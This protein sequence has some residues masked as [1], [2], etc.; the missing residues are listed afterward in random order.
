MMSSPDIDNS[1]EK[2]EVPNL[3]PPKNEEFIPY[4]GGLASAPIRR[5]FKA[6]HVLLMLIMFICQLV[7]MLM[8]PSTSIIDTQVELGYHM[9]L[10]LDM[11][12]CVT[13]FVEHKNPLSKTAIV[14][15]RGWKQNVENF[16]RM[17]NEDK[18]F[19]INPFVWNLDADNNVTGLQ[20]KWY[21]ARASRNW[22]CAV[23]VYVPSGG[24][25][26]ENSCVDTR[27]VN[28]THGDGWKFR[29]L[30]V[31]YQPIV[32][33]QIIRSDVELVADS[34]DIQLSMAD[35]Y[36][37]SVISP[38]FHLVILNGTVD[39]NLG[40]TSENFN[41]K[42]PKAW[43][44]FSRY[45]EVKVSSSVPIDVTL[46]RAEAAL[47]F[48]RGDHV[49]QISH[50]DDGL[51]IMAYSNASKARGWFN[52]TH[53]ISLS[54]FSDEAPLYINV[55]DCLSDELERQN[56]W[57]GSAHLE[58]PHFID[59]SA[60]RLKTHVLSVSA[61]AAHSEPWRAE[62]FTH[63][64]SLIPQGNWH[65]YSS[66]A[67]LRIQDYFAFLSGG[68]LAPES[69]SF[70][71]TFLGAFCRLK[72]IKR[73]EVGSG[74]IAFEMKLSEDGSSNS[75]N[76]TSSN[77]HRIEAGRR[78]LEDQTLYH[79]D[80]API[81]HIGID[82]SKRLG[83][84]L[85]DTSW[86]L[87]VETHV[88]HMMTS[89]MDGV[90]D[91]TEDVVGFRPS[92][93]F[94]GRVHKRL[95]SSPREE[96]NAALHGRRL[97]AYQK[98]EQE[99][100]SPSLFSDRNRREVYEEVVPN[101]Y[102]N[103]YPGVLIPDLSPNS[104]C[105]VEI[106]QYQFQGQMDVVFNLEMISDEAFKEQ[107]RHIVQGLRSGASRLTIV[108][109]GVCM[110]Y[111]IFCDS[112]R[113]YNALP[114]DNVVYPT[115]YITRAIQWIG[116]QLHHLSNNNVIHKL[117][118]GVDV[119]RH[120]NGASTDPEQIAA[121][122]VDNRRL[123]S[124]EVSDDPFLS[125]P[126]ALAKKRIFWRKKK[127]R[128]EKSEWMFRMDFMDKEIFFMEISGVLLLAN[129]L[130][131]I[132]SS[133]ISVVCAGRWSR[134]VL[135][136]YSKHIAIPLTNEQDARRTSSQR[137][138]SSKNTPSNRNSRSLNTN[139]VNV[140]FPGF[141]LTWVFPLPADVDNL[142]VEVSMINP[143][144]GRSVLHSRMK[145]AT[146]F[147]RYQNLVTQRGKLV[148][149]LVVLASPFQFSKVWLGFLTNIGFGLSQW[150]LDQRTGVNS[151]NVQ[152]DHRI[153]N[154][155][156]ASFDIKI[157]RAA[158]QREDT[159]SG[160]QHSVMIPLVH[161][162]GCSR[163][164]F[165]DGPVNWLNPMFSFAA[166]KWRLYQLR[167]YQFR[168]KACDKDGHV[169]ISSNW[170]NSTSFNSL[171]PTENLMLNVVQAHLLGTRQSPRT[172]HQFM[173]K[174]VFR[175]R[176]PFVAYIFTDIKLFIAPTVDNFAKRAFLVAMEN[177]SRNFPDAAKIRNNT[178]GGSD[179]LDEG[180]HR[181]LYSDRT[182][183]ED[184]MLSVRVVMGWYS[185][186]NKRCSLLEDDSDTTYRITAVPKIVSPD[187]SMDTRAHDKYVLLCLPKE[188]FKQLD[189]YPFAI[190]ER[191]STLHAGIEVDLFDANTQQRLSHGRVSLATILEKAI[192][193]YID[194][195]TALW[196][197]VN[198]TLGD[199]TS[200]FGHLTM[201]V[202]IDALKPFL[203][204]L[205]DPRRPP[206]S[207]RINVVQKVPSA[208]RKQATDIIFPNFELSSRATS[209]E[210]AP[211]P[212]PFECEG[213]DNDWFNM[214]MA[215]KKQMKFRIPQIS[216]HEII[217][218]ASSNF[219]EPNMDP[220]Q[221]SRNAPQYS[222]DHSLVPRPGD[223]YYE[224]MEL[225]IR[226]NPNDIRDPKGIFT[227]V[228]L[229]LHELESGEMLSVL[230][231]AR[232]A[233][234]TG[235][236]TWRIS[237]PK[238]R[239]KR[240]VTRTVR[241]LHGE[242]MSQNILHSFIRISGVSPFE[243]IESKLIVPRTVVHTVGF[244]IAKPL[245]FRTLE[246]AYA[247]WCRIMNVQMSHLEEA[248][249]EKIGVSVVRRS[250]L[251][252]KDF[253]RPLPFETF[254][255]RYDLIMTPGQMVPYNN[256][257]Q[258]KIT[259]KTRKFVEEEGETAVEATQG[260]DMQ[261]KSQK[262]QRET[263]Q[264]NRVIR[265][266]GAEI[267]RILEVSIVD[268]CHLDTFSD[269][270]WKNSADC[271]ARF[272]TF[273][274]GARYPESG[275]LKTIQ[276][277]R[278]ARRALLGP[279][280]I[281]PPPHD[282]GHEFDLYED[283]VLYFDDLM[284]F[285]SSDVF[286]G[287]NK[288]KT[289]SATEI[290]WKQMAAIN[291]R[292]L[293]SSK[294]S[295]DSDHK[296]ESSKLL[297]A[298]VNDVWKGGHL[299][300]DPIFSLTWIK[301]KFMFRLTGRV[302]WD[303][304]IKYRSPFWSRLVNFVLSYSS[305]KKKKRSFTGMDKPK[306]SDLESR[307]LYPAYP[308]YIKDS[309]GRCQ[310]FTHQVMELF[311][312]PP[313]RV[314]RLFMAY[315]FWGT[316]LTCIWM[317][318]DYFFSILFPLQCFLVALASNF[319]SN[320]FS[321][322]F[323]IEPDPAYPLD[324]V[325]HFSLSFASNWP[326]MVRLTCA[327]AATEI[328]YWL[329]VIAF[330]GYIANMNVRLSSLVKSVSMGLIYMRNSV[331]FFM[332]ALSLCWILV[333]ILVRST[334]VMIMVAGIALL[335]I[336]VNKV[337]V[338]HS[339]KVEQ[340]NA[341]VRNHF[342]ALLSIS[343]DNWFH[344]H[345]IE[346]PSHT[347][348][349]DAGGGINTVLSSSSLK[350]SFDNLKEKVQ[351]ERMTHQIE[352]YVRAK[353]ISEDE[354]ISPYDIC[355]FQ[356]RKITPSQLNS[357]GI[358]E[359]GMPS[360][361]ENELKLPLGSRLAKIA[362]VHKSGEKIHRLLFGFDAVMLLDGVLYG[363][364]YGYHLQTDLKPGM[365]F[366]MALI[367]IPVL[368]PSSKVS[369][370]TRVSMVFDIFNKDNDNYLN[371]V[372]FMI[373][374][375]VL[376]KR[377][378][379]L[380]YE[381][382]LNFYNSEYDC[383]MTLQQGM[384]FT[385][386]RNYYSHHPNELMID[387]EK[388]VFVGDPSKDHVKMNTSDNSQLLESVNLVSV[389]TQVKRTE[390]FNT[391]SI[392][393][394]KLATIFHTL[395]MRGAMSSKLGCGVFDRNSESSLARA[396]VRAENA[397]VLSLIGM[398]N[399]MSVQEFKD[400]HNH[401]RSFDNRFGKY[402]KSSGDSNWYSVVFEAH[403]NLRFFL[404]NELSVYLKRVF[405]ADNI[406]KKVDLFFDQELQRHVQ[407]RVTRIL[408]LQIPVT[409]RD[410]HPM[411]ALMVRHPRY[412]TTGSLL[413]ENFRLWLQ[414]QGGV[415]L[416]L[417]DEAL[418]VVYKHFDAF[419]SVSGEFRDAIHS[420]VYTIRFRIIIH[421]L[422]T[423]LVDAGVLDP[424]R[425]LVRPWRPIGTKDLIIDLIEPITVQCY[426]KLIWCLRGGILKTCG[427]KASNE[428][429]VYG[430]GEASLKNSDPFLRDDRIMTMLTHELN[431]MGPKVRDFTLREGFMTLLESSISILASTHLW[432]NSFSLLLRLGGISL[433]THALPDVYYWNQQEKENGMGTVFCSSTFNP[434]HPQRCYMS[435][436]ADSIKTLGTLPHEL[437]T[438]VDIAKHRSDWAYYK[439]MLPKLYGDCT[440]L[441][442]DLLTPLNNAPMNFIPDD[443]LAAPA[444]WVDDESEESIPGVPKMHATSH[445]MANRNK[446]FK[447]GSQDS[448]TD[449]EPYPSTGHMS[450]RGRQDKKPSDDA[451]RGHHVDCSTKGYNL[452]V[453]QRVLDDLT[454]YGEFLPKNLADEA[455]LR[456]TRHML[457]FAEVIAC[458]SFLDIPV[459]D[460]YVNGDLREI[461]Q[462][463][464]ISNTNQTV[465]LNLAT[466]DNDDDGSNAVQ[467][468]ARLENSL[469]WW[470][471]HCDPGWAVDIEGDFIRL[472]STSPGFMERAQMYILVRL[473][474]ERIRP[475][476]VRKG[477]GITVA[478]IG[479]LL[480]GDSWFQQQCSLTVLTDAKITFEMFNYFCL[481]QRC[482]VSHDHS[483][484]L[485]LLI[486]QLHSRS[487][488]N[489]DKPNV[490]SF[491]YPAA[492]P[493]LAVIKYLVVALSQPVTNNG[494]LYDG[495]FAREIF[496]FRGV[497][498]QIGLEQILKILR[499]DLKAH[500]LRHLWKNLS[501]DPW[502]LESLLA[503]KVVDPRGGRFLRLGM[504][505]F[506]VNPTKGFYIS[507]NTLRD[508][509]RLMTTTGLPRITLDNLI[510]SELNLEVSLSRI[511][512][513]VKTIEHRKNVYGFICYDDV[514]NV[515]IALDSRGLD[516]KM[517]REL[518]NDMKLQISDESILQMFNR[519]D[520]NADY[521][522]SL[523]E[524]LLGFEALY[525]L[526]LPNKILMEM[527][528]SSIH[529]LKRLMFI[530]ASITCSIVFLILS[531]SSFE[532]M[533]G[534]AD[535][536]VQAILMV[537]GAGSIRSS[538]DKKIAKYQWQTEEALELMFDETL[539]KQIE[540]FEDKM[541]QNAASSI[542]KHVS[543]G[544]MTP[545]AVSYIEGVTS[546][547]LPSPN[548]SF[549]CLILRP[550]DEIYWT[551]SITWESASGEMAETSPKMEW[552]S[553]P[554]LDPQLGIALDPQT[555]II[556]GVVA[557]SYQVKHVELMESEGLSVDQTILPKG[558]SG[559][560][561]K[562]TS[563][564]N[565]K[566]IRRTRIN[567]QYVDIPVTYAGP[568]TII[569]K[570]QT[571]SGSVS[572]LLTFRI[573]P[574][575]ADAIVTWLLPS[576]GA[577]TAEANP[578]HF[579]P[580]ELHLWPEECVGSKVTYRVKYNALSAMLC[581]KPKTVTPS[582]KKV[583]WARKLTDIHLEDHHPQNELA[584]QSNDS[585]EVPNDEQV[586]SAGTR[587]FESRIRR[588]SV[589][590]SP[591]KEAA[592]DEKHLDIYVQEMRTNAR[593]FQKRRSVFIG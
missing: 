446:I 247:S 323:H 60:R 362:D 226:W 279:S 63:S 322:R 348:Y 213:D 22:F 200:P 403:R 222:N 315:D 116:N 552:S 440:S 396:I 575:I 429:D 245:L 48:F 515:I 317:L 49:D 391:E 555:G 149:G 357:F 74:Q 450:V 537:A 563:D 41:F 397:T 47:S 125:S 385:G 430:S 408:S 255:G 309:D 269:Y 533:R 106:L 207:E 250:L 412:V 253:R 193:M 188:K 487:L 266:S 562:L 155:K 210:S 201:Q 423:F 356:Y 92:G 318:V 556:E 401:H 565:S 150:L 577:K 510:Q 546:S 271:S 286:N 38:R 374:Q 284:D 474:R 311:E 569:I 447:S 574:P 511:D 550:G 303:H 281:P 545:K 433:S 36:L 496:G 437:V 456:V 55:R 267:P 543:D 287:K 539:I 454:D 42:N 162:I 154:M 99:L 415:V 111:P 215:T 146:E 231:V 407:R 129:N 571:A 547:N 21:M 278:M 82:Y 300:S 236:F 70:S 504:D 414:S 444:W 389:R 39:I 499:I 280:R 205:Y 93:H 330:Q 59:H 413:L 117:K 406:I 263:A 481:Q 260:E 26:L 443:Y 20:V 208:Q 239:V 147:S 522:L 560:S 470:E 80:L 421:V 472:T 140:P 65:G 98:A 85:D 483:R 160:I 524:I 252:I 329:T 17:S 313:E 544:S 461:L 174:H 338:S 508:Q 500:Q 127:S 180:R 583:Q 308:S 452:Y 164:L 473:V 282:S 206:M 428:V 419:D 183:K 542:A 380:P 359:D 494:G 435:V 126:D 458:L 285:S 453:I 283:H 175:S 182:I 568:F 516:F 529:F 335:V 90:D 221:H 587:N 142:L 405:L 581:T 192:L 307:L 369:V 144:D 427:K 199:A 122:I 196:V 434:Q 95:S 566:R 19:V 40:G 152:V 485:W 585:D 541:K 418:F 576:E 58:K 71:M 1:F 35:L 32:E 327:W 513:A 237:L 25:L 137:L 217:I 321:G 78:L 394:M 590:K 503:E 139:R 558:D 76:Q 224:G 465:N 343:L 241:M 334:D 6:H 265:L 326:F 388:S 176:I 53:S 83:A 134:W 567:T 165:S 351:G 312:T 416:E 364:R 9:D 102:R 507:I 527:K 468:V 227:N 455:Y 579:H 258:Y 378:R 27:G 417:V 8:L 363:P 361:I 198:V 457:N 460:P 105:P 459:N 244:C 592:E 204:P 381:E 219:D 29:D 202:S 275:C 400:H 319:A 431:K 68:L 422:C 118:H 377:M 591:V 223:I 52:T 410:V 514:P 316:M 161:P 358:N 554:S 123:F 525:F 489:K 168:L 426:K 490:R 84:D 336:A 540:E 145:S 158:I 189:R 301:R 393:A 509:I 7:P 187:L 171:R 133:F 320:D 478:L 91:M 257:I 16:D 211:H 54:F 86:L 382:C 31:R 441:Y 493:A 179:P 392:N 3:N 383:R 259:R 584:E 89:A 264:V 372:E 586:E 564:G 5:M 588:G 325:F 56:T 442:P 194:D 136:Q 551:P 477:E 530:S 72:R 486:I 130:L 148:A 153:M 495:D 297:S 173:R 96:D 589:A 230:N 370:H 225:K 100:K 420:T 310:Q 342:S 273:F 365:C 375:N 177:L 445:M 399:A 209:G 519:M 121:L 166:Q 270:Y 360:G 293:D 404:E 296:S 366:P 518:I 254:H 190:L 387:Y 531:I 411:A 292:S 37:L 62:I 57:I 314:F 170:T 234:N 561:S 274:P 295:D 135:G 439:R 398:D 436:D 502:D 277:I 10:F 67:F 12:Y 580:D 228:Y 488:D 347:S 535:A 402:K 376:G 526:F 151:R 549:P 528:L 79:S 97:I 229:S 15:V 238:L 553:M 272:H 81:D 28:L 471:L 337:A 276:G 109:T 395:V 169:I 4:V 324:I 87:E 305:F 532:G 536:I 172:Q 294:R 572:T 113:D 463:F 181:Y 466:D 344:K 476:L 115:G 124:S 88:L 425:V 66:S 119:E 449:L 578:L 101:D 424:R 475:S 346:V 328:I 341:F 178:L 184:P 212:P 512:A 451:Q 232:N 521:S 298:D 94:I 23:T 141:N 448:S 517:L 24:R 69:Q 2:I 242:N 409:P 306:I 506:G 13:R 333:G 557:N 302:Q 534:G 128:L 480:Q 462:E 501:K 379:D 46:A 104:E 390:N 50:T 159:I 573:E 120:I 340:V 75:L 497:V 157:N 246:F 18:E 220:S 345:G 107:S 523:N 191:T 73:Q 131:F 143:G 350:D 197:L 34:I 331:F 349:E 132:L 288:A 138:S 386:L 332:L 14:S 112:T 185:E 156:S 290:K 367:K 256:P 299:T 45:A 491:K 384:S 249:L 261:K 289:R 538:N 520:V 505:P 30:A 262:Q 467:S 304:R 479:E 216:D 368:P 195:P 355:S 64:G 114:W 163:D 251:I 548:E 291:L 464:G 469:D 167:V 203:I 492:L 11:K 438:K 51:T 235:T 339:L 33:Q 214:L 559:K 432:L 240:K 484:F 61:L 218:P 373:W 352:T 43:S 77:V 593:N 570:C 498:S 103:F 354:P 371:P 482:S 108:W 268:L 186:D 233:R 110:K 248:N 243:T 353:L 582:K 44:F